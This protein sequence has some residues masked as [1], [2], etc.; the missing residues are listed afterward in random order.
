MTARAFL[1]T[2]LAAALA[3]D[4][5]WAEDP[6]VLVQTAAP[7]QGALPELVSAYGTAVPAFGGGLTLSLPQ[8]GR[9]LS[10]AVTPGERV[11][12]GETLIEFGASATTSSAYQQAT[13]ALTLART[14][15]AHTAQLLAQQLATRDQLA[16]ADKAVSDAKEAVD[17]L[18]AQGANRSRS[19]LTAPF[20]GIVSTIPVA[21]GDRVASGAALM[22]LT[23]LDGL[24][25]TVGVDPAEHG[26]IRPGQQ[27]HLQ[28]LGSGAKLDG[29]MR[30]ID[31]V[32]NP[33]TRM[34]DADIAVAPGSV[35][36]GE[37]F[38]AD[39]VI[40]SLQGWIVPRDAVRVT[41]KGGQIFQVSDGKAVAVDVT[42]LGALG[43]TSVVTGPV[44]PAR[45]MVVQGVPQLSD[46][47]AV[48]TAP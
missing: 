9:V 13:T 1:A 38:Q 34:V 5:A 45:P 15:R 18:T 41:D 39:I 7:Q 43:L 32:L 29:Q 12:A 35:L 6:S 36:S 24:V 48:R 40:G 47:A 33:K 30:R 3:M 14:Q 8:D 19:T 25:V 42:V 4:P 16:Q 20:D 23:R 37:A 28:R 17:T 11:K 10:I 31:G 26:R 44:D 2:I 21:Q 46:G 22:N 27:V